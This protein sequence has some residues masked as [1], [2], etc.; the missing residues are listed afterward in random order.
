MQKQE[1]THQLINL[2]KEKKNEES[3]YFQL[4]FVLAHL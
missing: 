4:S 2:E 1:K 3:G